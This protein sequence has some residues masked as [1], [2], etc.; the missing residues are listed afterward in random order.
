MVTLATH[1][2]FFLTTPWVS[3]STSLHCMHI[4]FLFHFFMTYLGHRMPGVILGVWCLG[5]AMWLWAGLGHGLP[6]NIMWNRV[7]MIV[8]NS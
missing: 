3:S 2:M 5:C 6:T 7:G 8:T 1:I 4:I